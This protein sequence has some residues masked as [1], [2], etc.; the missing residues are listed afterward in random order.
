MLKI[1]DNVDLKELEKFNFEYDEDNDYWFYYGFTEPND[2][3]EV[4]YYIDDKDRRISVGFDIYVN[5]Y[6]ILDKIYDLIQARISRKG[7]EMEDIKVG[8]YVRVNSDF[9]LIALGIGEVIRISQDTIYVKMNL[10]LPIALK[11]ENITKHSF[12]LIDLLEVGDI[13]FI[14]DVLNNDFIYIYD[15]EMLKA[16]KEN[17]EMGLE[18]TQILTH[19]LFEANCYKVKGE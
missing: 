18:I 4:R 17:I 9:R 10:D 15:D 7:V 8:E 12:N 19:E 3:S 2:Q 14:E 13:V 11:I 6:K 1:K 16:V 5:P